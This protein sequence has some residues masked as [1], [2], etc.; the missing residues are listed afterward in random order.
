VVEVSTVAPPSVRLGGAFV[1]VAPERSMPAVASETQLRSLLLGLSG[2]DAVGVEAR[3]AKLATRSLKKSTKLAALDL[4][5]S[6]GDLTTLEGANAFGRVR[7]L[8]HKARRPDPNDP[9]V[10]SAVA[11]VVNVLTGFRDELAPVLCAHEDVDDLDR[12]GVDDEDFVVQGELCADSF[13]RVVR[14]GFASGVDSLRRLRAF[15]DVKST[16]HRVGP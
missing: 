7:S 14:T 9:E 12:S 1:D 5:I 15:I 11:D 8:C 16:W 6:M 3:A 10:L 4:A 13:K 2:V